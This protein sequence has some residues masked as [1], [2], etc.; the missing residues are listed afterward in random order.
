MVKCKSVDILIGFVPDSLFYSLELT[1]QIVLETAHPAKF[2]MAV[3]R[4]LGGVEEFNFDHE[5][6]PSKFCHF[7]AGEWRVID[8]NLPNP[9]L[10]KETI[11]KVAKGEMR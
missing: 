10:I 11:K 2:S 1:I 7:L 4:A 6:F 5:V 9:V 3:N 8:V